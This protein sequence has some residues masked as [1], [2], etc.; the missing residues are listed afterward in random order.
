MGR[1]HTL[2]DT[3]QAVRRLFNKH[4]ATSTTGLATGVGGLSA[5]GVGALMP[6]PFGNP[7]LKRNFISVGTLAT[8][9]GAGLSL[10]RMLRFSP[11]HRDEVLA[12]YQQGEPL[13]RYVRRRLRP[14]HFQPGR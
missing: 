5:I 9:I 4:D 10:R 12:A 13:P 14:E 11:K 8:G 7:A 1:A 6:A 3:V 2:E